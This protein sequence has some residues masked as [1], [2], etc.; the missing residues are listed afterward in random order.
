MFDFINLISFT[1]F[2]QSNTGIIVGKN[3]YG[4]AINE[5]EIAKQT[6]LQPKKS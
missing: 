1:S 4:Q 6:K 5:R 2:A 3:Y